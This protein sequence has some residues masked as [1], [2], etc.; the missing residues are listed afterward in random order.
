MTIQFKRATAPRWFELNP[1]LTNGEPGFEY[2]TGKFKIGD[3][4]TPWRDLEYQ[5]SE[6]EIIVVEALAL[7]PTIGQSNKIYMANDSPILYR[8]NNTESKY[9]SLTFDPSTIKII[10]GGTAN[11]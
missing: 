3:G 7:L 11:G 10:N 9:E 2:D 1:V 8:W 5:N 4:K 6:N